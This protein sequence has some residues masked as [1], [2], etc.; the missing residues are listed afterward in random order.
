MLNKYKNLG[1]NGSKIM[2][3][4]ALIILEYNEKLLCEN[5]FVKKH[6]DLNKIDKADIL[7]KIIYEK[8]G[9]MEEHKK[10]V[11]SPIIF[12]ALS[13]LSINDTE[14]SNFIFNDLVNK[15]SLEFF[16]IY[17][18]RI[19]GLVIKFA[20]LDIKDKLLV[21][22]KKRD[23]EAKYL[24]NRESEVNKK[25]TDLLKKKKNANLRKN[26]VVKIL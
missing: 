24:E 7:S 11:R 6:I 16:S 5:K 1:L 2:K 22:I 17:K 4:N 8:F 23:S 21:D 20:K 13:I 25:L 10:L 15:T 3:F 18:S 19:I 12:E 26:T 9:E 14:I